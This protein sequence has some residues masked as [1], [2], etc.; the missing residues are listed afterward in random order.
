MIYDHNK[1]EKA[2]FFKNLMSE[3]GL[4]KDGRDFFNRCVNEAVQSIAFGH[5]HLGEKSV[6]YYTGHFSWDYPAIIELSNKLGVLPFGI[7]GNIGYLMPQQ[8]YSQWRLK[9]DDSEERFQCVGHE[10]QMVISEYVLP[11][12]DRYSTIERFIEDVELGKFSRYASYPS[13]LMPL[14]LHCIGQKEKAV[15]YIEEKLRRFEREKQLTVD[16]MTIASI[17]SG[18]TIEYQ[19]VDRNALMFHEFADKYYSY[20][21]LIKKQ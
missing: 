18:R 2:Q 14:A 17:L 20:I 4:K 6:T 15:E 19:H 13:E 7:G 12:M 9:K 5:S 11:F 10:I 1:L 16:E 8:E 3:L 21:G